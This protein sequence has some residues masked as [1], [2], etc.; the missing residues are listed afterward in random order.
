MRG[1]YY[2]VPILANLVLRI[3]T[4]TFIQ[5][6]IGIGGGGD[7]SEAHVRWPGFGGFER[8]SD[9]IDT[10][11]AGMAGVRFHLSPFMSVG[12]EYKY[13]AAIPSEGSYI[14]T[15]AVMASFTARF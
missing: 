15:H 14:A 8:N 5:P 2:Q 12:V 11:A 9:E 3:N 13:L 1:D 7:F 4:G 10:A 6:Y